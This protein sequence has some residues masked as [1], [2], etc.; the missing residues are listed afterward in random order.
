MVK[1]NFQHHY[2]SVSLI[3]SSVSQDPSEIILIFW[4]IINVGN[5]CA[6]SYWFLGHVIFFF[7]ILW[8]IKSFLNFVC[9]CI[10]FI[11]FNMEL[12][13]FCTLCLETV[14]M[15]NVLSVFAF[16]AQQASA[17]RLPT[18]LHQL[19]P[20]WSLL[21]STALPASLTSP[22]DTLRSRPCTPTDCPLTPPKAPQLQTPY[23]RP[24]LG[25]SNI[26]VYTYIH[27][28]IPLSLYI[29]IFIYI[30]ILVLSID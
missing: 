19:S 24:S 18:S 23:N 28:Y 6:A 8:F 4:N 25:C 11:C 5:C 26:Q 27:I 12:Q 15:Y 7:R 17:H 29:Y 20:A 21:L 30:F 14:P 22:T 10:H 16:L 9:I 1:L 13:T 3:Q 2:S